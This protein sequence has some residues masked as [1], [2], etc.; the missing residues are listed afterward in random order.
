MNRNFLAK[1]C[2]V[3]ELPGQKQK[4]IL[5]LFDETNE[6][7]FQLLIQDHEPTA[8][9]KLEEST[10]SV[11]D[12]T[13]VHNNTT[14]GNVT[15]DSSLNGSVGQNGTSNDFVKTKRDN[16]DYN[17]GSDIHDDPTSPFPVHQIS[18][19]RKVAIIY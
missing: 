19:D 9:S 11:Y 16:R 5:N 18:Q 10:Q 13:L 17:R 14:L 3:T 12:T 1:V 6:S 15:M 2:D 7:V 4:Y 8:K